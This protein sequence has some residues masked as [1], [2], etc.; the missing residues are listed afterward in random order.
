M[1]AGGGGGC[2]HGR[3]GGGCAHGG[4]G[5]VVMS[6]SGARRDSRVRMD[7]IERWGW[8][9]RMMG[10]EAWAWLCLVYTIVLRTSRY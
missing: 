9:N 4:D 8:T 7:E 1:E 6:G 2:T 10:M 3:D 5:G